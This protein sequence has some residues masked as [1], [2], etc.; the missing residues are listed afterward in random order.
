MSTA[1]NRNV[2][3]I[4]TRSLGGPVT[5]RKVVLRTIV[6]SLTTL[7]YRVVVAAFGDADA[8]GGAMAAGAVAVHQLR[9]PSPWRVLSNAIARHRKWTLN[10]LLWWHP[11]TSADLDEL[12]ARY[13]IGLVV[14]DGL[15]VTPY[16]QRL[17]RPWFVDLDDLLSDRYTAWARRRMSIG[18]I[19]GFRRPKGPV[20][21][22]LLDRVPA[23]ALLR[24]ESARVRA[25]EIEVA[26]TASGVSLVSAVEG[27][28]LAA[29]TGR[30]IANLPMALSVVPDG[31]GPVP[32]PTTAAW[33]TPGR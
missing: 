7:G 8:D 9:S 11:R 12:V 14:A 26:Q 18:G 17:G 16:A 4:S 30:E 27:R 3:L 6:E 5:G 25:R 23:G 28:R 15:R 1:R 13:D 22:A 24:L 2:L 29:R 21:Q 10:E 31:H 19:L 32:E 33:H 20:L